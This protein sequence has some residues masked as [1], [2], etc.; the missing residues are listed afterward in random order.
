VEIWQQ[1]KANFELKIT[2]HNVLEHWAYL[3]ISGI[4]IPSSFKHIHGSPFPLSHWY[5]MPCELNCLQYIRNVLSQ[6]TWKHSTKLFPSCHLQL[7]YY[8]LALYMKAF[9]NIDIPIKIC[10]LLHIPALQGDSNFYRCSWNQF[11]EWS[12][13]IVIQRL[14]LLV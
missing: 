2:L 8:N 14:L 11:T 13:S 9:A 4:K 7:H 6:D 1:S 10:W 5:H 3:T 12:K